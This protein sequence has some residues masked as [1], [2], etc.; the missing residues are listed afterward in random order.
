MK[1]KIETIIVMLGSQAMIVMGVI[2][3]NTTEIRNTEMIGIGFAIASVAM[4][5]VDNLDVWSDWKW[6]NL[7]LQ[8][9]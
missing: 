9:S 3:T 2:L 8:N 5:I 7:T 4:A 1:T 6:K